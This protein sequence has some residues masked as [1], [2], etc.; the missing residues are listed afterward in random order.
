MTPEKTLIQPILDGDRLLITLRDGEVIELGPGLVAP[1]RDFSYC[2]LSMVKLNGANLDGCRFEDTDLSYVDL[3]N[4]SLVGAEFLTDKMNDVILIHAVLQ[5][6]VFTL[7][8]VVERLRCIQADLS[9]AKFCGF[10]RIEHSQFTDASLFGAQFDQIDVMETDLSGCNM[11]GCQFRNVEFDTIKMHKTGAILATFEECSFCDVECFDAVL[12]GARFTKCRL[13]FW[14]IELNRADLQNANFTDCRFGP[15]GLIGFHAPAADFRG[16][17]FCRSQF[18]AA[19]FNGAGFGGAKV[20]SCGFNETAQEKAAW[21]GAT[22]LNSRFRLCHFKNATLQGT[23]FLN[24]SL[25]EA[26]FPAVESEAATF[27]GCEFG[28]SIPKR[29]DEAA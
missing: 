27:E 14:G 5:N 1:G 25:Q 24:C 6:A 18:F 12:N 4:A 8:G 10:G 23:K 29:L 20:V 13:G 17:S 7:D 2:D 15:V 21:D 9:Y 19:N 28:P 16:A 11:T 22:I 3:S 26:L